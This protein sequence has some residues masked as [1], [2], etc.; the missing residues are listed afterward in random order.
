MSQEMAR[1][2]APRQQ[3]TEDFFIYSVEFLTLAAGA[4][5][6]GNI[7]IQADSDFIWK[8]GSYYATLVGTDPQSQTY[9]IPNIELQIVDSG[10]GR[11]LFNQATPV[12]IMFG[13]GQLPFVLPTER[14]FKARSNVQF[15][16]ANVGASAYSL[17]LSLIGS[18][19]FNMR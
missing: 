1:P 4:V 15:S 17:T 14:I 8:M 12:S 5:R 6:E 16:I 11:Q 13:S 10:S 9:P 2:G 3:Y 19:I 7:Q 18:K